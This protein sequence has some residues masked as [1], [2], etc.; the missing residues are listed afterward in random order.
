MD[1]MDYKKKMQTNIK[2]EDIKICNIIEFDML[3]LTFN[4]NL[5]HNV[6]FI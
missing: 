1:N 6:M 3:S 4:D 2:I 5:N